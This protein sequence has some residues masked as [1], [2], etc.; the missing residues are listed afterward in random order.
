MT[1]WKNKLTK[2][3]REH[4]RVDAEVNTIQD[5][6]ECREAQRKLDPV[7]EVCWTCRGIAVKVDI[8]TPGGTITER[9]SEK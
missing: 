9:R 2:A 8:E 7:R 6:R 1:T 4:L 5:L 3:E